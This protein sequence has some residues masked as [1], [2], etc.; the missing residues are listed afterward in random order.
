MIRTHQSLAPA[1]VGGLA[2]LAGLGVALAAHMTRLATNW[3]DI[4]DLLALPWTEW[5]GMKIAFW[6]GLAVQGGAVVIGSALAV[7]QWRRGR[8]RRPEAAA[9]ARAPRA[10]FLRTLE[11][12]IARHDDRPYSL[13]LFDIDGFRILND[14][15][16]AEA[17]DAL[18]ADVEGRL[19][20]VLPHGARMARFGSDE[21]LMFV[22]D[23]GIAEALLL[24]RMALDRVAQ[25]PVVIGADPVNVTLTVGVASF[26]ETSQDLRDAISQATSALQ[27]AKDRGR[28]TVIAARPNK[29]GL[30]RLGAEVESALSDRRVHAAYQPIVNLQ[31]GQLVAEEGLARIILPQGQVL[32]ADQFMGAATDLRL[33]SR[34]DRVLIEQALDRCRVQSPQG[35]RRL[36]F[37]NVSAAL[38]QER[39]LLARIAAAFSGCDVLGE[40]KGSRNP[41]VVEITERELL[42]DP[43][44]ALQA[45]QPLLDIGARLAIDD[46]GSGYSSFL[47]LAAL[48]VSF[49]KIEMELLKAA[50]TSERVRCILKGI[51]GIAKDLNILT[52]AE[53]IEDEE[54][55]H[56]ARDHGMDWAQGFYFGRPVLDAPTVGAS[57]PRRVA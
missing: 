25:S 34:I 7:W 55:M 28:D 18:L 54:L 21:F 52:I 39:Q 6:H 11:R 30:C 36:R 35:D 38:L 47:Y 1:F 20:S 49:L 14:R 56:I 37:I 53:G 22:P 29:I 43:A 31:T 4:H 9:G 10:T 51:Q 12:L 13:I 46:F 44:A 5:L 23:R 2:A 17:A 41:L 15:H 26:P 45:L 33:V 19:V 16:G 48:P 40:L 3:P 50:R 24:A 27:E 8:R 42:R 57:M 32:G